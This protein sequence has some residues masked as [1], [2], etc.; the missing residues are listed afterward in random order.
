MA[1]KPFRVLSSLSEHSKR[2]Y[3]EKGIDDT[4]HHWRGLYVICA[5]NLILVNET[6]KIEPIFTNKDEAINFFRSGFKKIKEIKGIK[7]NFKILLK[8]DLPIGLQ[9]TVSSPEKIFDE[10]RF[11]S[12]KYHKDFLIYDYEWERISHEIDYIKIENEFRDAEDEFKTINNYSEYK[13]R[14]NLY[15][16]ERA[17]KFLEGLT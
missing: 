9:L 7:I 1:Q 17:I 8:D 13:N 4:S 14:V 5:R 11:E 10:D 6:M 2:S 16:L 3:L 15:L 12:G